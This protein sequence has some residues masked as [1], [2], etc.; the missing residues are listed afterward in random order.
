MRIRER[1]REREAENQIIN[2][3]AD[4]ILESMYQQVVVYNGAV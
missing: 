2:G 1:E 3:R 4:S